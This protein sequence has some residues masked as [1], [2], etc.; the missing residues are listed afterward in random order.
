MTPDMLQLFIGK[1]RYWVTDGAAPWLVS[2]S[3]GLLAAVDVV[4]VVD[5][6]VWYV[7]ASDGAMFVGG[8]RETGR[9]GL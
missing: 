4:V 6:E 8:G 2:D 3:N 9:V 1:E 5:G 7:P